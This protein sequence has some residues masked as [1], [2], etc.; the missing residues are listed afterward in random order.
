MIHVDAPPNSLIDSTM[1]PK[2]KNNERI[3]NWVCSLARNIL[4]I[5]GCAGTP[6]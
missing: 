4:R 1:N 6:E 5:K 2:V 3:K